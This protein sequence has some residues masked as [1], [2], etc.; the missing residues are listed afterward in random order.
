[1]HW[2]LDRKLAAQHLV[3]TFDVFA[4]CISQCDI[5]GAELRLALARPAVGV[6]PSDE[7]QNQIGP[8]SQSGHHRHQFH[9]AGIAKPADLT[10]PDAGDSNEM[11]TIYGWLIN[12]AEASSEAP[13]A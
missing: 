8:A 9:G 11:A 12:E 2:T 3:V 4:I 7:P 10:C 13:A 1:L 6:L 5:V